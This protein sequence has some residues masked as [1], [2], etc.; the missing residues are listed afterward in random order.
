MWKCFRLLRERFAA[1]ALL[2]LKNKDVNG[3]H[4]FHFM[5]FMSCVLQ[6]GAENPVRTLSPDSL[7]QYLGTDDKGI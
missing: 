2:L 6:N 5:F 1:L 7:K 4:W 3:V